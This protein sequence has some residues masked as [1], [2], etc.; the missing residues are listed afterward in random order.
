MS[1]KFTYSSYDWGSEHYAEGLNYKKV[2]KLNLKYPT[3]KQM[4][5]YNDLRG[6]CEKAGIDLSGMVFDTR[7]N[8]ST[9]SSIKALYSILG[10]HGYDSYGNKIKTYNIS[11]LE[12]NTNE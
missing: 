10:R 6:A 12:N 11:E 5:L 1:K 4:K 3:E 8:R 7:T 2:V 9:S